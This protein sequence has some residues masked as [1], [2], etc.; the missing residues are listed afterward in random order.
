MHF[1]RHIGPRQV[2]RRLRRDDTVAPDPQGTHRT[3][4]GADPRPDCRHRHEVRW[5]DDVRW[6]AR[7]VVWRV[8]RLWR[9][10]F[11]IRPAHDDRLA[12]GDLSLDLPSD[13]PEPRRRTPTVARECGVATG[14]AG[15]EAERA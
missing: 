1:A 4:E 10:T 12:R 7:R 9:R 3:P 13:Q 11:S 2:T 8:D 15:G 14:P 6:R 5:F